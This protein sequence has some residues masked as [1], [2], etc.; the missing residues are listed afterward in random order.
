MAVKSERNAHFV[1]RNSGM[2]HLKSIKRRAVS[3]VGAQAGS[4]L[5]GFSK[6]NH[7]IR[8]RVAETQPRGTMGALQGELVIVD[9]GE[10]AHS[11]ALRPMLNKPTT[12]AK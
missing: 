5:H 11:D 1:E 4:V 2:E 6:S 12:P 8:I 3:A 7:G 9:V 10:N